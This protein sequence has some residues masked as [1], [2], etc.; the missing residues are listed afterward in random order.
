MSLL[1]IIKFI[2]PVNLLKKKPKEDEEK[3]KEDEFNKTEK[4][5]IVTT[6]ADK[7]KEESKKEAVLRS[8]I[9]SA[10]AEVT[11]PKDRTY[12][13]GY[14]EL[15]ELLEENEAIDPAIKDDPQIIAKRKGNQI[16]INLKLK[17]T[18]IDGDV[19]FTIRVVFEVK[20]DDLV[21]VVTFIVHINL[22]KVQR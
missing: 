14:N 8:A 10:T 15:A 13:G 3:E 22:G 19:K 21:D 16:W 6:E 7:K 4:E 2:V 9:V 11:L 1:K 12:I 18:K 20:K 5:V 17:P